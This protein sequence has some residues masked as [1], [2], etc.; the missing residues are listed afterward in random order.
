[1]AYRLNWTEE[2][3]WKCH[4]LLKTVEPEKDGWKYYC[5]FCKH[6]TMPRWQMIRNLERV[7]GDAVGIVVAVH[8]EFIVRTTNDPISKRQNPPQQE[9]ER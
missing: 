6:L 9:S 8:C 7:E 5:P 2:L 1:V 4:N 3:C